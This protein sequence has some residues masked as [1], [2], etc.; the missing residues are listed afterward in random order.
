MAQT[1]NYKRKLP[2][3]AKLLL[4]RSDEEH[5][6]SR[7][8]M[9]E[10]LERWGLSAER[11]SIYDDME[12]LKEL[13]L[14]VQSRRGRSG[15]WYIG[16]RDFE[17]AEL[18]LLVD[19]VQSSR[20][21]TKRKSDALIRKLEGLTSVHQARQLQRQVYVDRRVKTM[22]ESI[23][24][25]VDKLQGAIAGNKVVSFHYFEYNARR[26]RVFR[27]EGAKYRLTPYGL[28]WDSENYYLAGWDELRKEVR[29]YRVDKM[30]DIAVTGMKGHPRGDWTAEGYAR[31]HFGMFAGTPCRLRL[32]CE[33]R[34]AGVVID[35]FGLEVALIPDG[36][37]HF[38][39]AL[40]LVASP[41]LWGWL[42]GLGP[43]VEVLA[44]AWAVDE[45]A[46]RLEEIAAL[47]RG[48]APQKETPGAEE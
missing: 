10:E 11:K 44:P 46:A 36:E 16:Q 22:N 40:D 42:F 24:Y 5:P 4:E 33:N 34:L 28:I 1:A 27:R 47:Y 21:L 32:R 18:K 31:R 37:E 45:F 6:V 15:G 3:L 39:A 17:L 29:H 48:R 8:E 7:Q 19:A 25:N 13:G 14:D 30:A 23:F 35:R 2:I 12:Q 20:F 41:P 9:Q 38:T 43:G 26:E